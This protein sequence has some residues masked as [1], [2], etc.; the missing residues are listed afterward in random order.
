MMVLSHPPVSP[1]RKGIRDREAV[2]FLSKSWDDPYEAT[3]GSDIANS[4]FAQCW[5]KL[6]KSDTRCGGFT[7]LIDS[8]RIKTTSACSP[9]KSEED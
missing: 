5:C 7:R 9:N 1:T 3:V 6:R 8:V 2:L 4:V